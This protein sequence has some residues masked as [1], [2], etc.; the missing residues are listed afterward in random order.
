MTIDSLLLNNVFTDSVG[1]NLIDFNTE[2]PRSNE[3]E[4]VNGNLQSSFASSTKQQFGGPMAMAGKAGISGG[5]DP[6]DMSKYT[7]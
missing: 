6:F 7:G 4:Y 5:R 2:L 1:S 3:P